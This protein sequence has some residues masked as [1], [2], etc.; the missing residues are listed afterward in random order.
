MYTIP[1][2]EIFKLFVNFPKDIFQNIV[3]PYLESPIIDYV[4]LGEINALREN[5]ELNLIY[6][7][8]YGF[9]NS[10]YCKDLNLIFTLKG[11]SKKLYK[12][13]FKTWTKIGTTSRTHYE[14]AGMVYHNQKIYIMGFVQD[15]DTFVTFNNRVLIIYDIQKNTFRKI[16]H[17]KE[18]HFT[19]CPIG[20]AVV[21]KDKIYNCYDTICE[22]IDLKTLKVKTVEPVPNQKN[23][24]LANYNNTIVTICDK[25]LYKF[26]NDKWTDVP[27]DL[28]KLTEPMV[29]S[30]YKNLL[31]ILDD[32]DAIYMFDGKNLKLLKEL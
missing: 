30:S 21:F 7:S 11:Q 20:S 27:C 10:V 12:Y 22:T 8:I 6:R 15:Y 1:V 24:F 9:L 18:Y 19:E 3:I 29:I 16:R 23:V 5:G 4:D 25:T 17:K 28:K 13:D 2:E 31:Y 26:E 14:I 32:S